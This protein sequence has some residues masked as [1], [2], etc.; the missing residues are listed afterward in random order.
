MYVETEYQ[1]WGPRVVVGNKRWRPWAGNLCYSIWFFNVLL[2]NLSFAIS[3]SLLLLQ[4]NDTKVAA[5]KCKINGYR[6]GWNEK[7]SNPPFTRQSVGWN[8]FSQHCISQV[9]EP[10]QREQGQKLHPRGLQRC[11]DENSRDDWIRYSEPNGI[12]GV[13]NT[14]HQR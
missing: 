7:N 11:S 6:K 5:H 8:P 2:S 10:K 9:D 1:V 4:V 14:T 12:S 3:R 13:L